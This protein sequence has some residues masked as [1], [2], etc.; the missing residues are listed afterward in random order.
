MTYTIV[1]PV[2]AFL[3]RVS[4]RGLCGRV[5]Y[6]SNS[7]DREVIKPGLD[8]G[9]DSGLDWTPTK[10]RAVNDITGGH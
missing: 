4:S 1:N 3:Y 7:A 6:V 8:S 9:L 2:R 5:I 10:L